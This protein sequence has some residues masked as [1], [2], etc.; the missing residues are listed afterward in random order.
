[1]KTLTF[2]FIF[3]ACAWLAYFFPAPLYRIRLASHPDKASAVF[4]PKYDI[5][6]APRGLEIHRMSLDSRDT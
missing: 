5:N 2:V 1:M 6:P 4:W 3:S